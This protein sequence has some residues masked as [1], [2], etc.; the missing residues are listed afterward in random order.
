MIETS[1]LAIN[2]PACPVAPEIPIFIAV[3]LTLPQAPFTKRMYFHARKANSCFLRYYRIFRN[4]FFF[5]SMRVG[6]GACCMKYRLVVFDFDGTLADTEAGILRALELAAR[7][8]GLP[9]ID[10]P[11][12][13]RGIG[14]PLQK[15]L[16]TALG[17]DSDKAAE[18]VPLYR[19]Y[20]D[21]VAYGETRLFPEVKET[22][23][24]LQYR[25]LLLA[26]A[27]SKGKPALLAMMRHLGIFDCFSF[28]AGEQDV[29]CKKP[30]PDM[31]NLA[32][33]ALGVEPHHCLVV[34]DTVYDIEMGQ[35]AAADTCAV[36]WG[37]NSG[38]ELRSLNPTFVVDS[39][40]EIVSL[41]N[42][43]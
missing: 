26:V 8:L 32:L 17:L 35:R 36:T 37:N 19:R 41:L 12:V 6:Q 18:A 10:W 28:V 38:D 33:G 11:T 4:I 7:D 21:E 9:G 20:Y 43:A 30:A 2:R 25:G 31:V 27:S 34:G 3:F 16:E 14:L 15:T 40:T 23:E 29:E 39:F 13:K 24:M 5:P 1:R 42:L 22:L